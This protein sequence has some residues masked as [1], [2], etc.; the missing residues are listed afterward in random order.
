MLHFWHPT[1]LFMA[2]LFA[3]TCCN[4]ELIFDSF[5]DF[6]TL[7]PNFAHPASMKGRAVLMDKH[8]FDPLGPSG[9]WLVCDFFF[10]FPFLLPCQQCPKLKGPVLCGSLSHSTCNMR[11]GPQ[12]HTLSPWGDPAC[13]G[14]G[15]VYLPAFKWTFQGP[16]SAA[17]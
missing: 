8:R 7:E 2:D 17:P 4:I 3:N 15:S 11:E 14:E 9:Q 5:L 16:A 6:T 1:L 12:G 13:G 10:F